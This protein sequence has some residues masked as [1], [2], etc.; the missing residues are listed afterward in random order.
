[1]C[2][3][4]V[5]NVHGLYYF[6]E[7]FI[8]WEL[9]IGI[10][11]G[12]VVSLGVSVGLDQHCDVEDRKFIINFVPTRYSVYALF[13]FNECVYTACLVMI[14]RK[15]FMEIILVCSLIC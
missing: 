13:M 12:F 15:I 14:P 6:L 7:L 3:R 2:D 9:L 8:W 1:M 4:S 5:E 10:V 11:C